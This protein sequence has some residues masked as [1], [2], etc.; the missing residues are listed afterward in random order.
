MTGLKRS[1]VVMGLAAVLVLG[2]VIAMAQQDDP[3]QRM[4]EMMMEM[5]QQE[6]NVSAEEWKAIQPLLENVMEK[7]Q[8]VRAG[9]MMRGMMRGMR[10]MGGPGGPQG[11]P[12][13]GPPGDQGGEGRRQRRFQQMEPV[14]ELTALQEALDA[15]DTPAADIKAKLD[16][17]RELRKKR[18]AELKKAQDELKAV[19]TIRQEA[20]L[21]LRGM[22]E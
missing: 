6:L 22:L 13:G 16:A 21:V 19:L 14:A 20:V 10:G 1:K 11:G 5:Y 12:P 2:A 18:E 15:E 17:F 8:Q 9:M 3:R 7:S 4:R